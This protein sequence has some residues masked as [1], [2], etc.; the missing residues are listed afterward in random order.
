MSVIKKVNIVIFVW[1]ELM[2]ERAKIKRVRMMMSF[3][4]KIGIIM[5]DFFLFA[6]FLHSIY[7]LRPCSRGFFL[8]Y[9]RVTSQDLHPS[10]RCRV[11]VAK[12]TSIFHRKQVPH[13]H[14]V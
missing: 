2:L 3:E 14:S 6:Y 12:A 13:L 10:N 7:A 5:I 9:L 8:N 4:K 11:I 1:E